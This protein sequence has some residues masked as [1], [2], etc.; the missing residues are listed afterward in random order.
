MKAIQTGPIQVNTW[1]VPLAGNDVFIVD[2]AGSSITGDSTAI[3]SYLAQ[4]HLTP[5]AVVLTHGHFDHVIGLSVIKHAYPSIKI[6]IHQ[7]D[8]DALGPQAEFFHRQCLA[9]M[10]GLS[11][12]PALTDL[13]QADFILSDTDTLD[14]FFTQDF[15][16]IEDVKAF[17]EWKVI[18]TPGHT[19]GSICLYNQTQKKLISGDTVFFQSYGRCD[20]F[21]GSESKMQASLARLKKII[22]GDTQVF[23]G[24]DYS[25]FLLS[26]TL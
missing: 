21:G 17:S 23:P 6:A 20:L 11:I 7:D 9:P 19:E 13:P 18:H 2:P 12:L 5:V 14:K 26:E 3:T 24:H 10:G 15:C 16:S 1:I 22:P 4:N 8:K 25:G